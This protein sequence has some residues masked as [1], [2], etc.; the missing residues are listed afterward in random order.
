M[1]LSKPIVFDSY[2][3]T[4]IEW[5]QLVAWIWNMVQTDIWGFFEV[6]WL[7]YHLFHSV[8]QG[9]K[10]FKGFSNISCNSELAFGVQNFCLLI[11][12]FLISDFVQLFCKDGEEDRLNQI[13]SQLIKCIYLI[14]K[15]K[16]RSIPCTKWFKIEK[17]LFLRKKPFDFLIRADHVNNCFSL[18]SDK[19][20]YKK[21]PF[22]FKKVYQKNN[23]LMGFI[24][25]LVKVK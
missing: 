9:L 11:V 19:T 15:W 13:F 20:Y 1:W 16:S 8:Q 17:T 5:K 7:C 23:F 22:A 12:F 24:K 6:L 18:I 25:F 2:W 3:Y 14:D 10:I 4:C 21:I